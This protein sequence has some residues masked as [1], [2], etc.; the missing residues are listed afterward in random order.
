[1]ASA[2]A[3]KKNFKASAALELFYTGGPVALSPDATSVACACS[4]DI[5]IV[6]VETGKVTATLKG[7]SELVTALCFGSDGKS[8]L[9]ASRSLQVR[10]WDISS[11]TCL[12][13]WKAHDAPVA[14]MVLDS[15]GG[16][17]A[18][19]SADKSVLVWDV[20]GGFCT[21]AFRGH[22]GIVT[23][24]VFHPDTKRLL[25]FSAS[26]D[27][28]VRVWDL[29]KKSCIH[30]LDKHFSAVTSLAVST[31]GWTLLSAGRDKVVNVWDLKS[32]VLRTTV[33][34][35]ET[36]EAVCIV[37]DGCGL[38]GSSAKVGGSGVRFLTVGDLSVVRVWNS[39][40]ASLLY[41]QKSSV[42][43]SSSKNDDSKGGILYATVAPGDR[44]MCVTSDQ[45]LLFYESVPGE[46]GDPDFKLSK[47][48]I[49]YNE[50]IIDLKYVGVDS[51][52]LAVA[53]NLE[54]V[55]IYD[56][57]SMACLQE[58]VGHTDIVLCLDTCFTSSGQPLLVSS[59]KDNSARLWDLETGTC[60]GIA[61]GHMAAVGAV[62]FSKKRKN[63]FVSGSSDR[64]I[65]LWPFEANINEPGEPS[66]LTSK[67]V[68]AAHDKDINALAVAPNDSL[69]CSASQ[70][71]TAKVWKL[72][73]LTLVITLAGH[74]RG[75][76]C[77]EFSP[78]DQCIMTGSGDKTI[79]IWSL[80]D[81]SCLKTFEGH[82]ASVLKVGFIT[83]GTQIISAGA[84]GLVKLW[85]IKNNECTNTFDNH[86]D[87]IWALAVSGD[88]DNIATG[89]ADSLVNLWVDC[90]VED[91]E[92]SYRQ[93]EEEALKDQ[94]LAN[95]LKETNYVKAVQLAFELKR[96]YRLLNVFEEVY[97][98]EDSTTQMQT[99]LQALGKEHLR[100]L[101]EYIRDWNS[102]SKF[103]HIAQRVMYSMFHVISPI[104]L[105]KVPGIRELLEG[106][107]PYSQRHF[108]RIDRLTRSTFL[109]D[110][111]LSSMSSLLPSEDKRLLTIE[112]EVEPD[113]EH[114]T[115][116]PPLDSA[117][118][119]RDA[120]LEEVDAQL[121]L[122]AAMKEHVDS[123]MSDAEV[124]PDVTPEVEVS[125]KKRRKQKH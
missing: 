71:R 76:W 12:R 109:L 29:L 116:E 8:L 79:R 36:L 124:V 80:S 119:K 16:L 88:G 108:S 25:L 13:S 30:I 20:D 43:S 27:G 63:F 52:R 113:I 74:K 37:P 84:D 58:L 11:G 115:F 23:S 92:E 94:D 111:V 40:G 57:E 3:Y 103:C 32:F 90:T 61:T 110:F 68:V 91:E 10:L 54:Q 121:E 24:V 56:M 4:D 48:L 33:P 77:V 9:S 34:V 18:T 65:K 64:T 104:D 123:R 44:I 38:P 89:G 6:D 45:C 67:A 62:V 78:V 81:G 83:R 47:R 105:I 106:I 22:K 85:T 100:L 98:N 117:N 69:V 97:R 101:L 2:L 112:P 53:T 28:T 70:D 1:M 21:H 51:T 17:L 72:P 66:K 114:A 73:E 7:D 15:S 5:K 102:K 19:A 26:D 82:T 50:E 39:E 35:Y 59:G 87:K 75:V 99:I 125:R 42:A 120:M 122:I 86:E 31:D 93:E 118:R 41:T 49:G 14:N 55:R 107:L 95:A 60:M 96:P 46:G